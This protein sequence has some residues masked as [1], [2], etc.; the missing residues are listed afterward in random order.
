MQ[1]T[2]DG[3]VQGASQHLSAV[4]FLLRSL[5]VC[6]D[7]GKA[8]WNR[9]FFLLLLDSGFSVAQ[10][11]IVKT[12]S[13]VAKAAL[14]LVV[15]A[16]E[17]SGVFGKV[18]PANISSH[19]LVVAASILSI[20]LILSMK[21]FCQPDSIYTLTLLKGLVAVLGAFGGLADGIVARTIK[22]SALNY[23]QQQTFHAVAWCVGGLVGGYLVDVFGFVV[24]FPLVVVSKSLAVCMVVGLGR[25]SPFPRAYS[26]NPLSSLKGAVSEIR[27][28]L[29]LC[30]VLCFMVV[31][32]SCFVV[33]DTVT[34]L[35]MDREFELS[36]FLL[37]AS[38]VVA[39]AGGLVVYTNTTQM[40]E[41][42]GRQ[43]LISL[44]ILSGVVF[45]L[46][47]CL[48]TKETAILSLPLCLLRGFSYAAI[49]ASCMNAVVTEVR[50]ELLTTVQAL[51]IGP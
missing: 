35:Q 23:S 34:F 10:V 21:S 2:V 49:W 50:Q 27:G 40:I 19:I 42:L 14:Q 39:M 28:N 15:P 9:F 22:L 26:G 43:N 38:P 37:A 48:L 13:I 51:T 4:L 5:T 36:K 44:G 47:H 12:S 3:N 20:P 45:L 24:L 25:L 30:K 41:R 33:V 6:L 1:A 46:A 8:I 32:G 7:V 18:L 16:M 31:W 29:Y 17:D 11:G